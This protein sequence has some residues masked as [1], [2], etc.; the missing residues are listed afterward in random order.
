MK[1][2]SIQSLRMLAA[3]MVV[4]L[5]SLSVLFNAARTVHPHIFRLED[6]LNGGV[7]IFFVISGF[8]ITFSASQYLGARESLR[9]IKKRFIR[10]NPVYYIATL[11]ILAVTLHWMEKNHVVLS[12]AAILKSILLLPVADRT[13]SPNYILPPAWTLGFEWLFYL[14]FAL[15]ILLRTRNKQLF[16]ITLCT[17]LVGLGYIL[18]S[19]DFRIRFL[20]N[21]IIL[22]FLLGVIIYWYYSRRTPPAFVAAILLVAG[23]TAY[24]YQAFKADIY[25][26]NA[27]WIY[28]R[29]LSF[30]RF[31]FRG[32]PAAF[33]F[34]GCVFLERKGFGLSLWNNRL[35][36]FLGDASYSIYLIQYPVYGLLQGIATKLPPNT[37][38]Y[39]TSVLWGLIATGIGVLFY[40]VVERPLIKRLGTPKLRT[41]S[42]P[43]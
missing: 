22:E 16:L 32:I 6:T 8:I 33:I 15:A 35:V 14:F 28:D 38:P 13:Q 30:E 39:L 23:V 12:S 24:L 9:F 3:L 20:T 42:A 36:N 11:L 27:A 21:P 37:H 34:F 29:S 2:R 26:G 31:L 19:P 25:L 17:I 40:K 1:I 18:D 4:F 43:G 41:V 7:D 10:I 5:H